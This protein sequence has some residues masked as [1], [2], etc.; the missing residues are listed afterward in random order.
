MYYSKYAKNVSQAD[1]FM[2]IR[3]FDAAAAVL[4][5]RYETLINN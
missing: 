4:I 3:R 2:A 1:V 5:K